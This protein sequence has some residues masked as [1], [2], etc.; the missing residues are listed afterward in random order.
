[1]W[2]Q[3]TIQ[4]FQ[5]KKKWY[6]IQIVY[7]FLFQYRDL[8]P[9]HAN[10]LFSIIVLLPLQNIIVD[11]LG[12]R[13]QQLIDDIVEIS[14]QKNKEHSKILFKLRRTQPKKKEQVIP[15]SQ[16]IFS[17][18]SNRLIRFFNSQGKIVY[19]YRNIILLALL[20]L[21]PNLFS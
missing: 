14:N 19:E 2:I 16:E 7:K 17:D 5:M 10:K 9:R 11:I 6:G 12:N 1:M 8:D 3:E 18:I 21:Y 15:G 20:P 4:K 13:L